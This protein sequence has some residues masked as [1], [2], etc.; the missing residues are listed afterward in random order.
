MNSEHSALSR[1]ENEILQKDSDVFFNVCH[2]VL[3][4]H[5][6]HKKYIRGTKK[7]VMTK[8]LSWNYQ[9]TT[10]AFMQRSRL[11]N[12]LLIYPSGANKFS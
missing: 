10:K 8:E 11:R 4:R 3:S 7:P 1:E 6:S 2:K 9:A 12:K 5:P